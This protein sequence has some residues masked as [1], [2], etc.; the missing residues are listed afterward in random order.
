MRGGSVSHNVVE[1]RLGKGTTDEQLRLQIFANPAMLTRGV[2]AV[3]FGLVMLLWPGLGLGEVVALFA[4]YAV[5]DGMVAVG[6]GV[7]ASLR[8]REGWPV[9]V[10]GFFSIVLGVA[11]LL[12][13]WQ[14]GRFLHEIAAWG[15]LTGCAAILAAA[16]APRAVPRRWSLAVAGTWS[17]FLSLLVV[18]L[19]HA[20]TDAMVSAIGAYALG[21]GVLVSIA[22]FNNAARRRDDDLTGER[23]NS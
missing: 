1:Q 23:S 21:F 20:V 13:P 4:S 15:I 6:W 8:Q 18:S 3:V 5:V 22:A 14:A 12:F 2:L 9:A 7:L 17:L 11:A 16:R 10:E 19:P